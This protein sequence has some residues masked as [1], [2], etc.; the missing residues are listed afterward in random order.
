[1]EMDSIQNDK[2]RMLWKQAKKRV[3]FK[4][5]LA[6]YLLVN[7]FLWAMWYFG[8][9]DKD[10]SGI[11]WPIFCSLGWGFGLLWHF[12]GAYIFNDKV[13]MVEKEF[14]KLKEKSMNK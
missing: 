3:G 5:H 14:Q 9:S 2:E 10:D 6:S 13:S 12:M 11:P 1:M 8:G 7:G 4:G